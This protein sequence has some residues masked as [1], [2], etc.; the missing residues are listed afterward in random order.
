[1]L[2]VYLLSF[3]DY[4]VELVSGGAKGVDTMV[5][6]FAKKFDIPFVEFPVTSND[7]KIFGRGAGNLRNNKMIEYGDY[8]VAFWDGK[9]R[10]TQHLIQSSKKRKKPVDI[11]YINEENID[12]FLG[13][14]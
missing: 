5:E 13:V 4:N 14:K 9:S 7:W 8:I 3:K 1:M 12:K 2:Q 10:G 6:K 11:I